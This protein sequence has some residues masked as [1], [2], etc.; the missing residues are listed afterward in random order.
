MSLQQRLVK[1]LAA[2]PNRKFSKGFLCDLARSTPKKYTG[3]NTG[4]RLRY[5][6]SCYRV[7]ASSMEDPEHIQARKLLNGARVMVE[8]R[9]GHDWYWL[10]PGAAPHKPQRVVE[11]LPNG[12]VRETFV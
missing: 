2:N 8:R 4:R 7:K 1:Y 11:Q 3:E 10:E 12:S 6:E 5:L 9:R